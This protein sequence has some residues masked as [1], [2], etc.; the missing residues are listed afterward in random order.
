MKAVTKIVI[1]VFT[2]VFILNFSIWSILTQDTNTLDRT[3][4]KNVLNERPS[5]QHNTNQRRPTATT[6]NGQI[7]T[8]VDVVYTWVNGSDPVHK[9]TMT[10]YGGGDWDGGYRDYGVIR[11]SIRSVEKF[12]PWVRNI[13]IVTNGQIPGWAN[14]SSPKLRIVSHDQ[15]F[16]NKDN[17]P[18]FNSNAIEANLY[19]I[20]GLAPCFLYLNDDMFV[21]MPIEKST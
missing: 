3:H 18:T 7:C 21:G 20:P 16:E 4:E 14:V 17:L 1:V 9:K 5:T 13:I 12:M 2:I 15:I 11:Y 19:N 8:E 10:K 6:K